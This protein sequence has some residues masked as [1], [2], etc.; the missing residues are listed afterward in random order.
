M[1]DHTATV[2]WTRGDL[3]FGYETYSRD[4]VVRFGSGPTLEASAAPAYKGS[5]TLANPEEM[6]VAALASCHMLTF[7]AIAARQKKVVEQYEDKAVGYLDKDPQGRIAVT[8]V[9]LRPHVRFAAG[10]EL[11]D[12]A[13][14]A[15]HDKAHHH[16]FIANSVTTEISIEPIS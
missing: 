14:T 2:A 5:P 12:A 3:A 11:D 15:M 7:L 8:R 4:H 13:L 1:S 16:C 9:V 10:T 6:L